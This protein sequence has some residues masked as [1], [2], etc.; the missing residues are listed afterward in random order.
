MVNQYT[1]RQAA[2][3][4]GA[5]YSRVWHVYAYGRLPWPRRV[6]KMFVLGEEDIESLKSHLD[7]APKGGEHVSDTD[8]RTVGGV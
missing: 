8:G 4:T 3:M 6:G 7:N 2:V 5:S 1:M